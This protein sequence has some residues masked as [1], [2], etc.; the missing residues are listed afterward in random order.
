[1][2]GY[3]VRNLRELEDSAAAHGFSPDLEA[4]FARDELDSEQLGISLQRLAPSVR[5]PFAHRHGE[6]EEIYVVVGGG[7]RVKLDDDLV[8]IGPWDA[9]RVAPETV[10]AFEA[11]PDGLELLALGPR[12]SSDAEPLP[13]SWPE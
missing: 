11:G 5:A 2:A 7:G 1:V 13:A 12:G 10:R 4:R 6:D 9:I 3:T 8:E